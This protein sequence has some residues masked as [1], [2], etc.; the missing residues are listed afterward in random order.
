MPLQPRRKTATRYGVSIRSIER[1]EADPELSFPKSRI[2]N[3]RR[4]DD[5]D[6][7]DAWDA[8]CAAAAREMRQPKRKV[9]AKRTVATESATEI[10]P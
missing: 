5:T 6:K 4:Y 9:S 7:L 8:V 2:I 10:Y 3:G 1:W